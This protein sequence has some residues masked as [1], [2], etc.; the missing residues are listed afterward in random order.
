MLLLNDGCKIKCFSR[1]YQLNCGIGGRS[2]FI[3]FLLE[4][5]IK[6][7]G[8]Q[9]YRRVGRVTGNTGIIL[10]G[11]IPY[12]DKRRISNMEFQITALQ[13]KILNE[14]E[15]TN[16]KQDKIILRRKRRLLLNPLRKE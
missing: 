4:V 10:F 3:I 11:L 6:C 15:V 12:S 13:S 2:K 16:D 9:D 7:L 8:S 5:P 1:K 14:P